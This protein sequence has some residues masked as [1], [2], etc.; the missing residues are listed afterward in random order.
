MPTLGVE[1]W[2]MQLN[3]FFVDSER[4]ALLETPRDE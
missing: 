3:G 1:W 4:V 2:R